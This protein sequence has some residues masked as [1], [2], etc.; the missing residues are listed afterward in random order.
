MRH[1]GL[2]GLSVS[3]RGLLTTTEPSRDVMPSP[4]VVGRSPTSGNAEGGL[5]KQPWRPAPWCWGDIGLCGL[6]QNG[7]ALPAATNPQCGAGS[8]PRSASERLPPDGLIGHAGLQRRLAHLIKG[9]PMVL[10]M[11]VSC[12]TPR[13]GATAAGHTQT[14]LR[15]AWQGSALAARAA[16]GRSNT[17]GGSGEEDTQLQTSP[18]RAHRFPSRVLEPV[19]VLSLPLPRA[20]KHGEAWAARWTMSEVPWRGSVRRPLTSG[21][22]VDDV[23][24]CLRQLPLQLSASSNCVHGSGRGARRLPTP[25]GGRH[26]RTSGRRR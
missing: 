11:F 5:R 24:P 3:R 23:I 4:T 6:G 25:T 17:S 7:G 15:W 12:R 20:S 16:R 1:G 22:G 9:V 14:P 8:R 26:A 13:P 21:S 2:R 10:D 19:F 18:S